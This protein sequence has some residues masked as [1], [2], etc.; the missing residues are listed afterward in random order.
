MKPASIQEIKNELKELPASELMA[1]CLRLA[2][3]KK[4]NKELLTFLL[5]EK[6]DLQGYIKAVEQEVEEGFQQMNTSQLY[7]AKKSL[8]KMLRTVN[9][10]IR[11]SGDKTAEVE[12]LLF[13]CRQL[14]ESGIAYKRSNAL[15]QLYQNQLKKIRAA[16]LTF[17][18]DLQHDYLRQLENIS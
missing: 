1:I 5:F 3:Y 12:L 9:K 14:K 17:H 13:F 11:Y 4:E 2:R 18:E 16:I 15:V 6:N 7:F 10:Y 8:R